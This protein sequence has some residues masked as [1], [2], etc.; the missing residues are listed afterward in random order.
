MCTSE[1]IL[2]SNYYV[3]TC[4]VIMRRCYLH[5]KSTKYTTF[6]LLVDWRMFRTF[7]SVKL[8]TGVEGYYM[9]KYGSAE[10]DVGLVRHG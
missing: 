2:W 6:G 7:T 1:Y 8:F 4:H 3:M 5:Y 10:E 9:S